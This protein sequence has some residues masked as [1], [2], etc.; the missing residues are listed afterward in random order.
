VIDIRVDR[1]Q[2]S[3][4]AE[5]YKSLR[6]VIEKFIGK[7]RD[8]DEGMRVMDTT[9][10]HALRKRL[11]GI[12]DNLLRGIYYSIEDFYR[13]S[14]PVEELKHLIEIGI[15]CLQKAEEEGSCESYI[16]L[17]TATLFTCAF[18]SSKQRLKNV[19]EIA[20]HYELTLSKYE[21]DEYTL[22][23]LRIT[24]DGKPLDEDTVQEVLHRI[25]K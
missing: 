13:V 12:P 4:L 15:E 24:K 6:A 7:F 2:F 16:N 1:I 8:F 17:E 14:A 19:M 5:L 22:L 9:S 23:M 3:D 21:S 18:P 20:S 10:L 25:R 11:K